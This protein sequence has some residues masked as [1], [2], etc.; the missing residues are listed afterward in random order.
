MSVTLRNIT[1][2]IGGGQH[3]LYDHLDLHIEKGERVGILGQPK[4]GKS[5]LL[6]IICGTEPVYDGQVERSSTVSWPIPFGELLVGS[7]TIATNIRFIG[8]LYGHRSNDYVRRI[9]AL[10]D[11]TEFL[12]EEL[13]KCLPAVRQRLIFALGAGTEF[14]IYLFDENI[15]MGEKTFREK[16]TQYVQSLVPAH[17][18]VFATS[19]HKEVSANCDVVFVLDGGR[20]TRYED[21]AQGV[22]H[23]N[24]LAKTQAADVAEPRERSEPAP[25]EIE[26][27]LG[28]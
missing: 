1:K 10:A 15:V 5:T 23:F 12:N 8:R 19:N 28:I 22:K 27:V 18:F 17:G 13:A 2:H 4:S 6:R 11:A 20:V 3:F 9:A 24:S 26:S 7:S 25:V 14:D 16:A 21:V